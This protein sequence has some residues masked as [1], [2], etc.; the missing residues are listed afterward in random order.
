[1]WVILIRTNIHSYRSQEGLKDFCNRL[2]EFFL[3]QGDP[4]FTCMGLSIYV[5]DGLEIN[6][7]LVIVGRGL[8]SGV[9]NVRV[10][11]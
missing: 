2:E 9:A 5:S 4:K 8:R 3:P 10:I 11:S 6:D 1:M 7:R